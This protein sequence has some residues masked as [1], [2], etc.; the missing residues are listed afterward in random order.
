MVVEMGMEILFFQC[1]L[2]EGWRRVR[3]AHFARMPHLKIEI[4][5]AAECR[6]SHEQRRD[7]WGT[8]A[9]CTVFSP[10]DFPNCGRRNL[11]LNIEQFLY[12]REDRG[13]KLRGEFKREKEERQ[14]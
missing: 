5:E 4:W 1:R 9:G 2:F 12:W 8:G 10:R 11:R 14:I 7:E 3:F 13:R 6:S